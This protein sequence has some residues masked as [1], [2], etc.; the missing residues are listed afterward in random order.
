MSSKFA[1]CLAVAVVALFLLA[2]CQAAQAPRGSKQHE[3]REQNLQELR[4]NLHHKDS[5]R[6][7][8][9]IGQARSPNGF[10]AA[11]HSRSQQVR[12]APRPHRAR[13]RSLTL[14][15]FY[16]LSSYVA[17]QCG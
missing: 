15:C 8:E 14:T 3:A 13:L 17:G 4:K 6:T 16:L 11:A 1:V 5:M 2:S 9:N 7:H 10:S 12:P